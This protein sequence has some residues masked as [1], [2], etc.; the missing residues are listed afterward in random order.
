[1]RAAAYRLPPGSWRIIDGRSWLVLL[2]KKHLKPG[3][4][5]NG[6]RL[7]FGFLCGCTGCVGFCLYCFDLRFEF[8]MTALCFD[9]LNS[10]K[11]QKRHNAAEHKCQAM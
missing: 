5:L 11:N 3:G 8:G 2:R 4:G 10:G 1:M 7:S 9:I 6:F